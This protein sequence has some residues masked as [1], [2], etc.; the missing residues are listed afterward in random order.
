VCYRL[1]FDLCKLKANMA[2]TVQEQQLFAKIARGLAR[3]RHLRVG[4]ILRKGVRLVTETIRARI[5][6]RSC[7]TVGAGARIAGRMRVGNDGSICIGNGFR[8]TSNFLPVELLTGSSGR[9]EIGDRVGIN[10]GAVIAAKS[11]VKIGNDVHMGPYCIVSD[12]D[13]PEL[14]QLVSPIE[15]KPIEIGEHT[16]LGGRVTVRPGVTIGKGAVITAGSIVESDIPDGVV[17]GGIPAR[18]LRTMDKD[19]ALPSGLDSSSC[20]V[21]RKEHVGKVQDIC[22]PPRFTGTL[23]SDFTIDEL[24]DELRVPDGF[25]GLGASIAPFGQVTQGLLQDPP[26]GASDFLVVWT[27]PETVVPAFGRAMAFEEVDEKALMAE[28]G[29]FCSLI[30][31]AAPFYKFVFVPTWVIPPWSRG[32]GMLDGRRGGLTRHLLSMNLQLCESLARAS[33]VFVLNAERWFAGAGSASNPKAWYLG[34]MAFPRAVM[35]EAASDIRAAIAG[36]TGGARKLLIVDLDDTLWGGIVGEVGWEGLRLGGH[37]GIGEAFVD[38]QRAVKHVKRRGVVLGIV[39][40][41]EESVALEAIRKHPE[42]VL[43]EDDFVGWKINWTDKA[44]NIAELASELNLGLGSV[45]FIDDNPVERARVREA[46][47]D[48]LVP[49]WPDDNLLYPSAF[50]RLRCFDTPTISRE[51]VERTRLYIEERKRDQFQT[52][53]GSIEEWLKSLDITVHAEPLGTANLARATQLLNKTNQLNLTTRRMTEAELLAWT[54]QPGHAFWTLTVSDRFGSAGLTGLLSIE[55]EGDTVRIVDYVLSCRVMGR[56]VEETMVHMAVEAARE[57]SASVVLAE[58][59]ATAKNRP[60]LTF[61]QSCGFTNS[62]ERIFRWDASKPYALP[63]QIALRW[64]K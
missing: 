16:W 61:W 13:I 47:P 53:V 40:K 58:Y 21:Q 25:G 43:R 50:A 64:Q 24:A 8:V 26:A 38:F 32:L 39:S 2:V 12:V 28:V 33:N 29:A 5:A 63:E 34:K 45:V 17:A 20:D 18:V 37:D 41:N 10:F 54:A 11:Q 31:R 1:G 9:I 14:V 48:V 3:D 27:R 62:D 30:E 56:K 52:Q 7:D 15:P 44:L 22:E 59:R 46:L 6:L 55:R 35:V 19:V 42:M 49:E 23:V 51:D 36:L 60:C 57:H 4:E